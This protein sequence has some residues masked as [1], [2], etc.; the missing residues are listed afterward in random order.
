MALWTSLEI[1]KVTGG[2]SSG[3][4][5]VDGISIDSRTL[6]KGDLFVALTD[7]RDGHVFPR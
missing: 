1:K 2:V 6:Q 3:D 7:K 5:A 4:W